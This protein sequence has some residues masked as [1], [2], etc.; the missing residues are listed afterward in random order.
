MFNKMNSINLKVICLFICLSILAGFFVPL[1]LVSAQAGTIQN[2]I[3]I[4]QKKDSTGPIKSMMERMYQRQRNAVERMGELLQKKE[5]LRSKAMQHIAD[6]KKQGKDVK[7][8]EE[9]LVKFD[10]LVENAQKIN[11]DVNTIVKTHKGFDDKG[12][13]IDVELAKETLKDLER[14]N[15]KCQLDLFQARRIVVTGILKFRI[16]NPAQTM[17]S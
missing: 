14:G 1:S 12:L 3:S 6:L 10:G 9:M 17:S 8:L 4:E 11:G 13:V 7:A 5:D 16:D 15:R 2:P